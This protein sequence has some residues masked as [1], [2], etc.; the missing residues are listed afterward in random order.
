MFWRGEADRQY[1]SPK[2]RLVVRITNRQVICQIVY[3]KLQ[4]GRGFA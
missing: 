1:A 2:Y 4:V 3:A